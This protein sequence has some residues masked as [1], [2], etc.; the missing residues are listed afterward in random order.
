MCAVPL[1]GWTQE[2]A[3]A[4]RFFARGF[5]G[6]RANPALPYNGCGYIFNMWLLR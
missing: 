4:C 3:D 2:T 6:G 1:N 5:A